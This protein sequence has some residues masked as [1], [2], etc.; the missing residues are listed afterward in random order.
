LLLLEVVVE[1]MVLEEVLVDYYQT[2][3]KCLPQP[4]RHL[5]QFL[6]QHHIQWL[7]VVV[8]LLDWHIQVQR[9][10]DREVY[11]LLDQYQQQVAAV[12]VEVMPVLHKL[13]FLEDLAAAQASPD[14]DFNL[15]VL[16]LTIQVQLNKDILAVEQQYMLREMDLMEVAAAL[17][18][19]V[20]MEVLHPRLL[21]QEKREMVVMDFNSQHLPDHLLE[22]LPFHH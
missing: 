12:D 3:F 8:V 21:Q 17:A 10:G 22:F 15:A 2:P 1:Q 9:M 7:L 14:L 13:V 5:F 16:Q 20:K 6:G 4:D 11:H 19:Q 18:R